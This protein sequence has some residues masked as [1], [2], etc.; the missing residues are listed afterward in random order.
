MLILSHRGYQNGVPEN[1]HAAFERA[2]AIGVDG[3][4]TDVRMSAD[5]LPILY[6]DHFAP[7]GRKVDSLSR[8]ELGGLVGYTVP[9]LESALEK[10]DGVLWNLEIKTPAALDATVSIV[11]QFSASRRFLITSRIHHIVEQLSQGLDADFGIVIPRRLSNFG[12]VTVTRFGGRINTIVWRYEVLDAELLEE[13]AAGGMRNLVYGTR[14]RDEHQQCTELK[15]DGIITDHPEY[16]L[17][18]RH[19]MSCPTSCDPDARVS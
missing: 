1:T 12:T 5:R 13:T 2:I 9:T 3:I 16:L 17:K 18:P 10:W 11:S 14:T 8:T 15:I 7:D 4:E 6:H 19:E